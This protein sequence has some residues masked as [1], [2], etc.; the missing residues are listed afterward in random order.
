MKGRPAYPFR[1]GGVIASVSS[2]DIDGGLHLLPEPGPSQPG[3][4]TIEHDTQR[5]GRVRVT[6]QLSCSAHGKSARRW[7]WTPF[8]V[9]KVETP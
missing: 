9:T 6:Y 8:N 2:S 7:F 5:H 1:D 3:T 4:I